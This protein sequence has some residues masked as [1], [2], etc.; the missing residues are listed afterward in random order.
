MNRKQE[1]IVINV[2]LGMDDILFMCHVT[3]HNFQG[4]PYYIQKMPT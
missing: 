3:N 4:G 2:I 1:Q